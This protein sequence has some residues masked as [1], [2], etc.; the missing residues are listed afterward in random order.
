MPKIVSFSERE[1]NKKSIEFPILK[2]KDSLE[3]NDLTI[4]YISDQLTPE[5]ANMK[6]MKFNPFDDRNIVKREA[7]M[8]KYKKK[9]GKTS[10]IVLFNN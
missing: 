9:K 4:N 5:F 10:A 8:R 2:R 3:K 7:Y 6:I 1:I